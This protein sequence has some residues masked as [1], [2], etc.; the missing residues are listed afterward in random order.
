MKLNKER[1][2][3]F[4][5]RKPNKGNYSI[6]KIYNLI[7]NR[8]LDMRIGEFVIAK[9]E[10][11]KNFDFGSF[12]RCFFQ[13]LISKKRLVH[14]TGG[15]SYMI[16]AF[17]FKTRV[18]TIHDFYHYQ[19]KRG[20]QKF[21]YDTFF[22]KLP[23]A[24]SHKIVVVSQ[25]TSDEL[26]R[27]FP[28]AANKIEILHNPLVIPDAAITKRKRS[29]DIN[30]KV[31]VLQIG[32]KELKN[33]ERLLEATKEMNVEYHF[34]HSNPKRILELLERYDRKENAQ[35]HSNIT[36]AMLYE[37]YDTSDVLFFASEAEGFGLPIIEAQAYGLPVITS[38]IPPMSNIGVGAILVDPFS[39]SSIEQGFL[40]LFK[41]EVL[42][43]NYETSEANVE[44]YKLD[45]VVS[46]YLEFYRFTI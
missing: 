30:Q 6:E 19:Q 40:N 25:N 21:L 39:V 8:I 35:I 22:Y 5:F 15:C 44:K 46:N 26:L 28:K 7:Y 11:K 42:E 16:L 9:Y 33:Y 3:L 2:V 43:A 41:S 38:N 34:V 23:V 1:P 4:I 37:L 36:D 31:K 10:L 18:L 14:V 45:R 13:A 12:L 29:F 27:H 32:D 24:F 20:I 17:P